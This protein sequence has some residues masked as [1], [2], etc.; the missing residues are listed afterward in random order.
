MSYGAESGSNRTEK[1]DP[2]DRAW[3]I[4]YIRSSGK[5]VPH[6]L[7]NS[8]AGA[9]LFDTEEHAAD[10]VRKYRTQLEWYFTKFCDTT[11]TLYI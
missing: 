3:T 8:Y 2:E 5:I 1:L 10:A 7:V 9:I 4:A 11:Q 6:Y